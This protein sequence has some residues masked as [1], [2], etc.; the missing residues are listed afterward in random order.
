V[1]IVGIFLVFQ[2]MRLAL[3]GQ[4]DS[5]QTGRDQPDY[6]SDLMAISI[7]GSPCCTAMGSSYRDPALGRQVTKLAHSECPRALVG[8]VNSGA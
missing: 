5:L 8:G 2:D 7:S 4:P 3:Q 1:E 6:H